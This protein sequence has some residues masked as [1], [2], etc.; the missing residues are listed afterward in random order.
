[1]TL[2]EN[3]FFYNNRNSIP[4]YPIVLYVH[5]S[6]SSAAADI[7]KINLCFAGILELA[8]IKVYI[9]DVDAGSSMIECSYKVLTGS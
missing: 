4:S 5:I 1:M 2:H 7:I 6:Q 8:N 9:R 3:I